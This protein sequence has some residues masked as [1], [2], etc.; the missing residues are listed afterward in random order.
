MSELASALGDLNPGRGDMVSRLPLT[1]EER[2]AL[3]ERLLNGAKDRDVAAVLRTFGHDVTDH[4]VTY[5]RR[6]LE[7]E[8]SD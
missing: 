1:K 6:K 5:Y 8:R 2:A 4:A 3:D 7:R